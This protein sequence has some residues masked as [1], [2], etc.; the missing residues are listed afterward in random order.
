MVRKKV[1]IA[2]DCDETLWL[3]NAYGTDGEP[4]KPIVDIYR[5]LQRLPHVELYVWSH[6]GQ[7]WAREVAERCGL[8][9]Y[10][11]IEKPFPVPADKADAPDIAF[12]D[13]DHMGKV[14]LFVE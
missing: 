9:G 4:N 1:K 10:T 6:G 2:F 12:D 8:T 13:I 5:A 7:D 14:T 3:N 11:I